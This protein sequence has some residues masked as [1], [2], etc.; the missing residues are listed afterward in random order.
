MLTTPM[1]TRLMAM[2]LTTRAPELLFVRR[3]SLPPHESSTYPKA[4]TGQR[5]IFFAPFLA[6]SY[7]YR[8][9]LIAQALTTK[10]WQKMGYEA[11][12]DT[13]FAFKCVGGHHLYCAK[14]VVIPH[15]VGGAPPGHRL[16]ALEGQ[17]AAREPH[18]KQRRC[19][20]KGEE[21]AL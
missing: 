6:A 5:S 12:G 3:P 14:P 15:Q 2:P 7:L 21:S 11:V 16:R 9:D 8:S 13:D 20:H 18:P 10:G 19:D 4:T 17:Q 1:K